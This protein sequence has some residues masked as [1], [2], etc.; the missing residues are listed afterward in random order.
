MG[1]VSLQ[2]IRNR[3][4]TCRG[5]CLPT[6]FRPQGLATL[7]TAFS[8][9]SRAGFLSH[10]QR[11]WD[12]PFG[13]F[14]SQKVS[15]AFPRPM[16]P[17]T[18]PPGDILAL[19]RP[20]TPMPSRLDG[21]RFLGFVPSESPWRP[22][23]GLACRPLAAPLGFAPSRAFNGSL[24]RDFA[25]PP[26]ARFADLMANHQAHRRPRVSIGSR[27]ASSPQPRCRDRG[28]GCPSRVLH[29]LDPGHASAHPP[30]LWVHLA[31]CR[32]FLP[33]NQRSLG[34]CPRST[35]VARTGLR[36]RA[37]ALNLDSPTMIT[38]A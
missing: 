15:V 28:R 26:L 31:L 25:Q 8:L 5:L 21:L 36:C 10:R 13:A 12:S 37:F 14:S 6:T 33:A 17:L 19:R 16:H 32:T 7:S 3:R 4:S 34:G 22:S 23:M 11:S 1:S 20:R 18:V 27:L 9:R 29:R 24:G 35:G 38:T 2:H 30:G